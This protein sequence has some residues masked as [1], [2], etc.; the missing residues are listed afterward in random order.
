MAKFCGNCGAASADN[1]AVCGNCG[2]PF[3]ADNAAAAAAPKN[4]AS[5]ANDSK[6][7]LI[8]K[9]GMIAI[10]VVAI[11]VV[12][13]IIFGAIVPNVGYKGT[14]NKFLNAIED[15]DVEKYMEYVA[16]YKFDNNNDADDAVEDDLKDWLEDLEYEYGENIKISIKVVDSDKLTEDRLE[17]IQDRYDDSE[18]CD[19]MEITKGY[20]VLVDLTVKGKDMDRESEKMNFI[21]IKEDGKWK[22]WS[23]TFVN[24]YSVSA[25]DDYDDYDYYDY[26]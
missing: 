3:T 14:I 26:Y 23:G 8:K 20:D 21:V 13:A 19:D 1:A 5:G 7:A 17:D 4:D 22:I 15:E 9:I 18:D 6:Q 16:S 24:D 25:Y 11:I 2:A 10:P 12:L